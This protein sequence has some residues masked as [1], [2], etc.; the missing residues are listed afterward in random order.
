MARYIDAD[1][2]LKKAI[3]PFIESDLKVVTVEDIKSAPT[4]DVK[5]IVV[6]ELEKIKAE[7][8]KII[9]FEE[10]RDE[11]ATLAY[12]CLGIV[13]KELYELKGDNK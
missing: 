10:S 9:L 8:E 1:E 13:D 4:A 3:Y 6:E 5:S 12:E 2:L 7:I 11:S